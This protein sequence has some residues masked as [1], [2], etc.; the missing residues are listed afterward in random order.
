VLEYDE[1]LL[2]YDVEVL[3]EIIWTL[4]GVVCHCLYPIS[5]RRGQASVS[6]D[7]TVRLDP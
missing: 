5:G 4:L 7:L 2:E 1:E 3:L 6:L